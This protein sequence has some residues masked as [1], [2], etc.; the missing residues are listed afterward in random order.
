MST[1]YDKYY[2][3]LYNIYQIFNY[4]I[5][6]I[7]IIIYKYIKLYNIYNIPDKP[8]FSVYIFWLVNCFKGITTLA[9]SSDCNAY[10]TIPAASLGPLYSTALP[11]LPVLYI[12]R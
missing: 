10:S 7:I 3:I 6:Y 4:K 11:F 1:I 2:Y 5:L 12:Y 8:Q 9:S